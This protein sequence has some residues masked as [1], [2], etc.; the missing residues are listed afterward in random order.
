[1]LLEA[2]DRA[3]EA[4]EKGFAAWPHRRREYY[5]ISFNTGLI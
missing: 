3:L 4:H 1:M 5:N 2:F